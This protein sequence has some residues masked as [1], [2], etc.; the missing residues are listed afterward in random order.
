MELTIRDYYK[1]AKITINQKLTWDETKAHAILGMMSEVGEVA[2]IFQKKYQGH[3]V[4]KERV[5]DELGDCAWFWMEMCFAMKFDPQEVLEYNI[6]KLH[7]RYPG[8]FDPERSVHR[9]V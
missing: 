7:K 9:E 5:M 3:D 1:A 4:D 2:G 6:D 8:G